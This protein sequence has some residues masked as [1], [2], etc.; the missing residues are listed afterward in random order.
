MESDTAQRVRAWPCRSVCVKCMHTCT[1]VCAFPL[2]MS[3]ESHLSVTTGLYFYPAKRGNLARLTRSNYAS[4]NTNKKTPMEQDWRAFLH[5]WSSGITRWRLYT[6]MSVDIATT[7]KNC[8]PIYPD[9]LWCTLHVTLSSLVSICPLNIKQPA[10]DWK[11][12]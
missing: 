8:R 12:Y 6:S 7:Q 4:A 10:A 5:C 11:H 1:Y 9:V 3:H 2:C